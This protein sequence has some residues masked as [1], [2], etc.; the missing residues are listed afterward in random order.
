M[1]A[2]WLREMATKFAPLT[3]PIEEIRSGMLDE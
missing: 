2:A 1:I 3:A